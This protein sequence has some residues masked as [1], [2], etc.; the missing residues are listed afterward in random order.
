MREEGMPKRTNDFQRLIAAIE[1]QL[2]PLGAVVT[3]SKLVKEIHSDTEREI[4]IAIEST[5]GQHAVMIGIECRDHSRPANIEWIDAL[6][7]KYR[8][9]PVDR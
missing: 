4:D 5:V 9:I 8:Y 1:S 7:G 3:E 6:I 2:A